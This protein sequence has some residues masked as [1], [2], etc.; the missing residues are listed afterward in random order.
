MRRLLVAGGRGDPN[1]GWLHA[2]AERLGIATTVLLC[3][4]VAPPAFSWAPLSGALRIDGTEV[5]CDAAFI[6]YDVFSGVAAG[7]AEAANVAGAWYAAL[8]GYCAAAGLFTLNRDID[9]V[10]SNKP[11][12]LYLAHLAGLA[13][14]PTLVT[15]VSSDLPG[16]GSEE[17]IAK[18]VAGGSYVIDAAQAAESAK[19]ING[20]AA[21]PAVVQP[22]LSYPARRIYR[23]GGSYFAFDIGASTLDSRLDPSCRIS[24]VILD[25]LPVET[26]DGIVR[27]TDRVRCDFCAIDMKTDPNSGQLVFLELNNGPMFMG[28]DRTSN[29]AMAEAMARYLC[30][31]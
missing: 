23:V 14:S 24:P 22:R 18:P 31:S 15:N 27:L 19:W 7:D 28:Y 6:R 21:M 11:A 20:A 25:D 8:S 10:S 26:L 2:A 12:M 16:P 4:P 3:D 1:L 9:V 17:H 13:V 5:A 30:E 29:G